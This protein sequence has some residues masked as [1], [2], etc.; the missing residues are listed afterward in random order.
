V[1]SIESYEYVPLLPPANGKE[2]FSKL[3]ESWKSDIPFP[4]KIK[5]IIDQFGKLLSDAIAPKIFF[6]G[7]KLGILITALIRSVGVI[8]V[9]AGILLMFM[10]FEYSSSQFV[11]FMHW[12]LAIGTLLLITIIIYTFPI[13]ARSRIDN[14]IEFSKKNGPDVLPIKISTPKPPIH[15]DSDAIQGETLSTSPISPNDTPPQNTE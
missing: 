12:L 10:N 11:N 7:D 14:I 5:V 15:A 1:Y 3:R 9:S 6:L 8:C 13:K 2:R 4:Q